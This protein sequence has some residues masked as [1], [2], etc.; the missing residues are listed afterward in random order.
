MKTRNATVTVAWTAS[1]LVRRTSG[2][3]PGEAGPPKVPKDRL[4]SLW[5]LRMA[6]RRD[7]LE[8]PLVG[9]E[10]Y[11]RDFTQPL[12]KST[13]LM[14]HAATLGFEHPITGERIELASE[15][16]PDFTAMLDRLQ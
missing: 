9:E 16:P 2:T 6:R 12:I 14:L 5:L 8:H 15:L 3:D 4:Q 7:M 11:I 13:R 10:V 1:A